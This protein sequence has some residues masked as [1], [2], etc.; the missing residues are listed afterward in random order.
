MTIATPTPEPRPKVYTRKEI[1]ALPTLDPVG[2]LAF[3]RFVYAMAN[4]LRLREFGECS[5]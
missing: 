1:N 4:G 5:R 2:N 3:Q